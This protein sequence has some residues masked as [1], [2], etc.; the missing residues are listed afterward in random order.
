MSAENEQKVYEGRRKSSDARLQQ[1][2]TGHKLPGRGFSAVKFSQNNDNQSGV[3]S[4][5][6]GAQ[7]N[8]DSSIL[9]G[10]LNGSATV[11]DKIPLANTAG[12]QM[13]RCRL[14]S[15]ITSHKRRTISQIGVTPSDNNVIHATCKLDT[16]A[17]A[18]VAGP[19]FVVLEY[20]DQVISVTSYINQLD[21][22][23]NVPVV[24]AET[25]IDNEDTGITTILIFGQAIY[26]GNKIKNT[27]IC[28]N[29]LRSYGV[30]VD[31][32]PMHLSPEGKPSTHSIISSEDNRSIPMSMKG[33]ISY[34]LSRTP[35]ADEL[36]TCKPVVL[37]DENS[38]YP[39]VIHS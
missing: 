5:L 4:A 30:I 9:N 22:I 17:D 37:T 21:T 19:N 24:T 14:S 38:W 35:T 15:F 36:L 26:M 39:I 18:C 23:K 2:R 31:D 25:A 33:I 34:F 7:T 8:I 10:V 20:T 16:H 32:V 6:T 28:P 29:Q 1:Q 12:S 3:A 27:P 13:P 11:G